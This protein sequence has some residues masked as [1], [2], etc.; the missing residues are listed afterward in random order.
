M[1]KAIAKITK[2]NWKIKAVEHT[3]IIT[4]QNKRIR[5]V[6]ENRDAW[7]EKCKVA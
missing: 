7:N 5:E 1:P 6:T 3:K 2:K 4:A